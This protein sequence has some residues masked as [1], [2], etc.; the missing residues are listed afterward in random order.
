MNA[1]KGK[2][3][4]PMQAKEKKRQNRSQQR[5]KRR[6]RAKYNKTIKYR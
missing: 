4:L 2:N 6:K 3:S 5:A 1:K